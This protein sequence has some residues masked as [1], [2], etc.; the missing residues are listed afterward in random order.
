MGRLAINGGE[1]VRERAFPSWPVYDEREREALNEVLESGKWW[2]GEKVREFEEKFA[3]YQDANY[4]I[5]TTNGT[6]ALE[7]SLI[8]AGV[9]AGY[10]VIIPSYTF[11]ATATAVLKANAVPVFVDI[12]PETFNI[13][14]D[15]IEEAITDRTRAIIPVHFGGLPVDMDEITAIARSHGLLIIEDAAH[16]WGSRWKGRGVGAIG[17]LGIFSFQMSKNITAGEG[18]IILTND[19]ELAD[20]CR[21]YTN[22]GRGKEKPWYEHYLLGGNYRMTEFQAAILLAQLTRLDEQVAIRE[23]N[24]RRLDQGLS[25]LRGISVVRRDPR[26][27]RRSY[28]LYCFRY[29]AE[30]LDGVPRARFIEAMNAEG[31]PCYTGYPHPVYKNPLFTRK[32][33]GPRYCPVSC[34]Y[35]GG[36]MDYTEVSCPVA[37]RVCQEAVWLK[38]FV[39]LGTKEDMD[40]IIKAAEKV[41][42]NIDELR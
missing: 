27:T 23:E 18:G 20:T 29:H 12:E 11:V 32:G 13:D 17:D 33:S 15:K 30:Q 16:A 9:G 14:P 36:D 37:E 5:T 39:L 6:V 4:G 28:H 35:Y 2:Y 3:A 10:E 7:I 21:S 31:I 1:K 34:P 19:E 40:D 41:I 38:Q 8:S 24:A 22:C 26:V 42:E 25:G